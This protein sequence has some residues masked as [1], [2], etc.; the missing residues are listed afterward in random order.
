[1]RFVKA[2]EAVEGFAID[3]I[4]ASPMSAV[5][6]WKWPT[7]REVPACSTRAPPQ[8]CRSV[9]AGGAGGVGGHVVEPPAAV[10]LIACPASA[11]A[12]CTCTNDPPPDANWLLPS[13]GSTAE[14]W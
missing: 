5:K 13:P 1:M 6:P 12:F 8:G 2:V 4:V 3:A 14:T 10:A 9:S 11:A 7:T